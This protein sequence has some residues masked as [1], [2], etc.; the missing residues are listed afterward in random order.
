VDGKM[1]PKRRDLVKRVTGNQGYSSA[2]LAMTVASEH[3]LGSWRELARMHSLLAR[4]AGKN[5]SQPGKELPRA[6]RETEV[7]L[8]G[9]WFTLETSSEPLR[10]LAGCLPPTPPAGELL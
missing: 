9:R 2:S 10:L 5:S 1:C 8:S 4:P 6:G 3:G 7:G